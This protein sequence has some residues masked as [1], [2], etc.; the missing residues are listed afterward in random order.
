M[1]CNYYW[2]P[3]KSKA[4]YE[5]AVRGVMNAFHNYPRPPVQKGMKKVP[6]PP[7]PV[8]SLSHGH[9]AA[10]IDRHLQIQQDW[11]NQQMNRKRL[12]NNQQQQ[13]WDS[14]TPSQQ[15]EL[16][17]RNQQFQKQQRQIPDPKR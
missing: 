10:Q 8:Q 15:R 11:N 17:V 3:S 14:L 2:K 4:Q 1:F 9:S 12:E 13:R 7:N 6:T 5:N 16:Y